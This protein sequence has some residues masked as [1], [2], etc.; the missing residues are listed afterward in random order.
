[1]SYGPKACSSCTAAGSATT[2]NALVRK[3]IPASAN[4]RTPGTI[5]LSPDYLVCGALLGGY[6]QFVYGFGV[7]M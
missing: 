4:I 2:G 5:S 6:L 3:G 1:M 7:E